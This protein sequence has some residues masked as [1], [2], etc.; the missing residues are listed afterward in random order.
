MPALKG[1]RQENE[2][3]EA[4]SDYMKPCDKKEGERISAKFKGRCWCD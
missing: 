3:F 4:S 1:H 2:E